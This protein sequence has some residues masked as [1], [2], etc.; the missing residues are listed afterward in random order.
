M[1]RSRKFEFTNPIN[2]DTIR[3]LIGQ[4]I[5]G[6]QY[7]SPTIPEFLIAEFGAK[8]GMTKP[9]VTIWRVTW[10]SYDFG[11]LILATLTFVDDHTQFLNSPD[12][13]FEIT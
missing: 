2:A 12:E 7:L 4:I 11:E 1:S 9:R 3:D 13:F 10:E 5:G 8:R 6:C